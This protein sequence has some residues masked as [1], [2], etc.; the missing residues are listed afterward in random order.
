M[1]VNMPPDP[2]LSIIEEHWDKI[3][4]MY[5][6]FEKK[7]PIIEYSV[8]DGKIYSYP[9]LDYINSLTER[10]REQTKKQYMEAVSQNQFIL[11]VKDTKNKRLRSYIFD[12]E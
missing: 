9:P 3:L 7:K 1:K 12:V 5:K 10:T 11:F 4:M 2:Y 6:I 8:D